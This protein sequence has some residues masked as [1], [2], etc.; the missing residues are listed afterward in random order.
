MAKKNFIPLCMMPFI[1]NMMGGKPD[2]E[3]GAEPEPTYFTL[4]RMDVFMGVMPVPTRGGPESTLSVYKTM[5]IS[6]RLKEAINDHKDIFIPEDYASDGDYVPSGV[7]P[8]DA[9][10]VATYLGG[11]FAELEGKYPDVSMQL[12]EGS[13]HFDAG[14]QFISEGRGRIAHWDE[15]SDHYFLGETSAD[16]EFSFVNQNWEEEHYTYIQKHGGK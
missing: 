9:G 1:A 4:N 3:G 5:L 10:Q 12:E 14:Y 15:E 8:T 7:D 6:E 13:T 16:G 11:L 2:E